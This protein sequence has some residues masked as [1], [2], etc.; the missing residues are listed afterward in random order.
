MKLR[1]SPSGFAQFVALSSLAQ[2]VEG[3]KDEKLDAADEVMGP[4]E[5]GWVAIDANLHSWPS[6]PTIS[7][8]LGA[9]SSPARTPKS[10][11]ST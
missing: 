5:K 11:G 1:E 3:L 7:K 8:K 4:G 2:V 10:S 9:R 6:W